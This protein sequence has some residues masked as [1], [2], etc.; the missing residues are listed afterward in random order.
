[1]SEIEVK[2][3][4]LEE[5]GYYYIDSLDEYR[6]VVHYP[7]EKYGAMHSFKLYEIIDGKLRH[8]VM[9]HNHFMNRVE[10]REIF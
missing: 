3:K 6:F 2:K 7:D 9:L 8:M 10:R 4:W 5:T 1:M